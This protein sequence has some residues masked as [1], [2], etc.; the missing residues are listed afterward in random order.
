MG[1][2][3]RFPSLHF[4][5]YDRG[6]GCAWN[7]RGAPIPPM[8]DEGKI[9]ERLFGEEDLSARRR[10]LREDELVLGALRRDLAE[11]RRRGSDPEKIASY[12]GV[13]RE[14]EAQLAHESF[15]IEA[16]KPRVPNS[17]S[18]D[19]EFAFSTKVA[20]LFE[21]ATLALRT[22]STRILTLSLDWIYGSIAVPGASGGW[23]TLSHH[24]GKADMIER[25][26]RIEIDL[27]RHF[28]N[29][30]VGLDA[31]EEGADTTLLDRTTVVLGSNFGDA[32]NHT[33][34]NL[35]TII[36]GGGHE[37]RGHRVL[38]G[39][40]PLCNLWLELA[41]RH[42]LGIDSFGSSEGDLGLLG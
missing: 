13:I 28:Q 36:A 24:G 11:L 16:E 31:I 22:D 38:P 26:S 30:L 2:E 4:S 6:W 33:C 32:S 20:N 10:Q 8:H 5:I 1:G 25:L 9:F 3:T 19:P 41:H 29:F 23:H 15:W 27:M 7:D 18:D 34:R 39:P 14:M 42:G 37:H 17:L 12:A 40:T 35:P 21:L